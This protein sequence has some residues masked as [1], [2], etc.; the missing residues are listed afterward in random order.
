[1]F[2]VV[3][4]IVILISLSIIIVI[5]VRKF[6]A[7]ANLDVDNMPAEKEA[8]FKEKL[9][10]ERFK[11]GVLKWNFK[12]KKN[13]GPAINSIRRGS[14]WM[15]KKLNEIKDKHTPEKKLSGDDFDKKITSLYTQVDN[16]LKDDNLTEAEKLLI[17]IIGLNSKDSKAFKM[18]A[19]LYYEK[20]SYEE[21]CQTYEH[22]LKIIED[23]T[24]D[25]KESSEVLVD[26]ARLYFD[27]SLVCK[28][29]ENF[30]DAMKNINLALEI[31]SN[32]PRFLDTLVEISIMNK[33]KDRAMSA[34][35]RLRKAN[36]DNQKLVEIEE[37]INL[38]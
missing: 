11:R 32:N 14:S 21:A 34:L 16:F 10:S 37:R 23:N 26:K 31:E 7:L 12:V 8:R 5:V 30:S 13:I 24:S 35:E 6:S 18:L 20:K 33:E 1:M 2:N 4:L 25:G 38:L 9:I 27:I 22:V 29:L 3:P 19:D 28:E 15:Y 36:P 17:E